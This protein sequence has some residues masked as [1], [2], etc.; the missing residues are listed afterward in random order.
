MHYSADG[1]TGV[2]GFAHPGFVHC[3]DLDAWARAAPNKRC[4]ACNS[5][6]GQEDK[7]ARIRRR[8]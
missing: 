6:V 5:L 1:A 4:E 3:S 8:S 2:C 7:R